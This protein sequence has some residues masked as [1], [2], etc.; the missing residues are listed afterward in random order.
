MD[1]ITGLQF[2]T[3]FV[4]CL[5]KY[6]VFPNCGDLPASSERVAAADTARTNLGKTKKNKIQR[7]LNKTN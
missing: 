5:I 2:K 1:S 4:T 7:V 3:K 6:R